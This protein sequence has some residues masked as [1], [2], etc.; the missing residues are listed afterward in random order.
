MTQEEIWEELSKKTSVDDLYNQYKNP[1][2]FQIELANLINNY[3]KEKMKIIEVGCEFGVSSML[4][5]NSFDKTLLDLNEIALN[6]SK[7]VFSLIN[8]NADFIKADMFN[9]PFEKE[10]FDI[11]FNAG[12]IEHFNKKER[13]DAFAEYSRILKKDGMYIN[14]PNCKYY[15]VG[16]PVYSH[17]NIE[18][19][20]QNQKKEIDI[21]VIGEY[22][23][24]DFSQQ[25]F[26]SYSTI[27]LA[28][29]LKKISK[30]YNILVR[31]R[32]KDEYYEDMRSI[33]L[34]SVQYS[35]PSIESEVKTTVMDDIVRSKLVLGV[36]TNGIHDALL[37]HTPVIQTNFI[38]KKSH[39]PLHENSM[40]YYATNK[41]SLIQIIDDFFN[42]KI[43]PLN[44]EEHNK[45]FLNSGKFSIS[46]IEDE[47]RASLCVE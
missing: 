4:L 32:T 14:N 33:L 3:Y 45:K 12:V 30:K 6:T 27:Q 28:K 18:K 11:L 23:Y 43:S 40:V 47:L 2:T 42:K 24:K 26:N 20:K 5:N 17:L 21:L 13:T 10:S 25:P 9:M 19:L 35:I 16:T 22:Y 7:K 29:V 39:K 41:D 34:N 15:I 38:L 46:T 31:P 1:A 8:E 44:Y 37:V 36:F